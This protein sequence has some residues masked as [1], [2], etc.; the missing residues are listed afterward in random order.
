MKRLKE[1]FSIFL[2]MMKIGA[3]TFGGGYAMIALLENEFVDKR[4]W[5]EKEE[6]LDIAAIAESTPGP[7]AINASTYVGYKHM[8]FLGA[9]VATLGMC[10]PSFTV[11]YLISLFFDAFLSFEIVG[12]A[13]RGI[14]I[15]VIYII[16]SAG[17]K[18]LK[19]MK[20]TAFNLSVIWTVLI[21]MVTCSLFAVNFSTVFYILI[22]GIVGVVFYLVSRAK[23][24]EGR[25]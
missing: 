4:G 22:S 23:D 13:F 1:L 19:G 12:Y 21:L 2:A 17:L 3:F 25:A 14:Q 8:G 15:G 20:K 11:I 16:F 18:M 10:L 5:L 6:F 7:I 9:L 24:K